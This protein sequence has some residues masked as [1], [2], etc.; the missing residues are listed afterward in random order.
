MASAQVMLYDASKKLLT[1]KFLKPDEIIES[2]G[3]VSLVGYL[4]VIG[5]SER[6]TKPLE[7]LTIRKSTSNTGGKTKTMH[8]LQSFKSNISVGRGWLL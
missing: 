1:T 4:V 5:A 2:G 3:S 6:D 7:D 8:V